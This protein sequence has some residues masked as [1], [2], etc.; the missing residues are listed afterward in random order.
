MIIA[1]VVPEW[2]VPTGV[3]VTTLFGVV[4]FFLKRT[5]DLVEGDL[6]DARARIVNLGDK[7]TACEKDLLAFENECQRTYVEQEEAN[8]RHA[9]IDAKIDRIAGAIAEVREMIARMAPRS[10][11]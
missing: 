1:A 5:L 10:M 11:D 4:G 8:V 3:V 9:L 7:I 6:R 2:V